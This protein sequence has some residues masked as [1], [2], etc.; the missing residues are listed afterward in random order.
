MKRLKQTVF[1]VLA[2]MATV[3][4]MAAVEEKTPSEAKELS[5]NVT[6]FVGNDLGRNGAYQQKPMAERMGLLAD[7]VGPDAF[8]AL[9]DVHHYLGIQSVNDP[10]WMTNYELI[11]AHPE[12]QVEWC[13]VLGNHEYCGNTQAVIDYSKVSR[14]WSMP[15]RRYVRVFEHK[16]TRVKVVF[17]DTPPLIDKYHQNSGEYPDACKQSQDL[18]LK[19]LDSVL[20]ADDKAHWT[21][22]AGHHPVFAQTNKSENERTDMQARVDPLLRKHKVDMYIC[23]HIHNFQHIRKEGSN[24][25]YV[26]NSSASL[27]RKNVKAID[28]TVFCS[29]EEGFSIITADN[30]HLTLSMVDVN[31]KILHQVKRKK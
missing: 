28:G 12:L 19:W 8:L 24:V 16:G 14:R 9:G 2:A 17:I 26:V 25:D 3:L 13:P 22:V 4:T 1:I 15:D 21:I 11:Y 30:T 23:G 27:S 7:A 10:L 5:G 29:G 6:L 31:G 18:A 20:S